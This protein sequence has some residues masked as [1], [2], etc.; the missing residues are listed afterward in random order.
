MLLLLPF[1]LKIAT[2]DWHPRNHISF[3]SNH[4]APNNVPFAS[5]IT[6]VHPNDPAQNYTTLLWPDHCVQGT[7]GAELVPELDVSRIDEIIEKG[8]D[9]RVEM[10][11]AFTDPFHLAPYTPESTSISTS[12]LPRLLHDKSITHVYIVG[13][14]QDY[15][16]RAS[17]IDAVRFGYKTF[18]IREGTR[19]VMPGAGWDKAEREMLDAGVE[20]IAVNGKEVEWVRGITFGH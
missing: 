13:L 5:T 20:I 1:T 7:P 8:D 9:P 15:C 12:R 11:S 17:A 4:P 16:V 2:K 6:I 19:A 14:A 18:V 10:Y 3:A